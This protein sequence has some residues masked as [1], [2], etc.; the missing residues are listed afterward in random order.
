MFLFNEIMSFVDTTVT[1]KK[2]YFKIYIVNF[3]SELF[4]ILF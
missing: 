2:V 1:G 4:Q 3:Y